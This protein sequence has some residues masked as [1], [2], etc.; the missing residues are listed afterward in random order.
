MVKKSRGWDSEAGIVCQSTSHH[1]PLL[2]C[3]V[4]GGNKG[5]IWRAGKAVRKDV[6]MAAAKSLLIRIG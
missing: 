2:V 6:W 5:Y 1:L 4:L 3:A